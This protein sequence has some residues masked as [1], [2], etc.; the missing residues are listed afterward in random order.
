MCIITGYLRFCLVIRVS[1]YGNVYLLSPTRRYSGTLSAGDSEA[2]IANTRQT[3][4]SEPTHCTSSVNYC[5]NWQYYR[6]ASYV[7]ASPVIMSTDSRLHSF[8]S[9]TRKAFTRVPYQR[10]KITSAAATSK[11][12]TLSVQPLQRDVHTSQ[13][14]ST[15]EYH[16]PSSSHIP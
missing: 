13:P 14:T 11:A 10:K 15:S 2:D 12:T 1:A 3:C 4:T 8:F 16:I 5:H 9:S 7:A 6:I